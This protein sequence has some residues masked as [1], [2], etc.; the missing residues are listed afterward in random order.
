L[1][2]PQKIIRSSDALS[3]LRAWSLVGLLAPDWDIQLFHSFAFTCP[4]RLCV[5]PRMKTSF[6]WSRLR[7][8]C[9]AAV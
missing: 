2:P 7:F 3:W 4:Y 9:D 8:G 1:G 6:Q 5:N